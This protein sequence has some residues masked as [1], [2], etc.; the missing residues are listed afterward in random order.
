MGPRLASTASK[1]GRWS[2]SAGIDGLAHRRDVRGRG[3]AA[4]ADDA[5][6]GGAREAGVFR[7]Q[8]GRAAIVHG[9][10]DPFG[11]AAIA[12][13]DERGRSGRLR[14]C[15]RMDATRSPGPMPQLAP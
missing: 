10:A 6:A 11:D 12:L 1:V 13:G 2:V 3:A 14:S 7:H 9:V 5:G 8:L 4:P 15:A